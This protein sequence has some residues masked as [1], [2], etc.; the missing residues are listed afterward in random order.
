MTEPLHESDHDTDADQM[1]ETP[2]SL[3]DADP[4]VPPMDRGME[5]SDR[6]LAAERF[7]TTNAE[8]E[9]GEPLDERIA[10]EVP[11]VGEHDPVDD[12]VADDPATFARSDVDSEQTDESVLGDAYE[13]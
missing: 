8:A 5:A 1:V 11:D 3:R 4:E 2:Q 6:P 12:I 9:Q 13:R 7:G 10:E